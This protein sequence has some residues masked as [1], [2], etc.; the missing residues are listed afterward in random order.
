[1]KS[2]CQQKWIWTRL[3]FRRHRCWQSRENRV[4][5]IL[6]C[7][8][9]TLRN[10]NHSAHDRKHWNI[11]WQFVRKCQNFDE[12]T[13]YCDLISFTMQNKWKKIVKNMRWKQTSLSRYY[14]SLFLSLINKFLK[15]QSSIVR[16][17]LFV[18]EKLKFIFNISNLI[19][20]NYEFLIFVSERNS[21]F[22]SIILKSFIKFSNFNHQT[23]E[24]D[25]IDAK[26]E[27]IY[28]KN[29]ICY[30]VHVVKYWFLSKIYCAMNFFLFIR[31]SFVKNI[32][33]TTFHS[34]H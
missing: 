9:K 27:N 30:F 25:F 8:F 10:V 4:S 20:T 26:I 6:I 14:C 3:K 11:R 34:T 15:L 2:S 7:F 28:L 19:I 31:L 16:N 32:F 22:F 21:H 13:K 5:K 18:C 17:R 33:S 29:Q 12:K 24:N 23:Y 1:M